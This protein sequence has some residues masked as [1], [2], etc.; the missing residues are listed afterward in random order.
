MQR[1]IASFGLETSDTHK[2]TS[3]VPLHVYILVHKAPG[4]PDSEACANLGSIIAEVPR[5]LHKYICTY[6]SCSAIS[7]TH[8]PCLIHTNYSTGSY[9]AELCDMLHHGLPWPRQSVLEV[10]IMYVLDILY[11]TLW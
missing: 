1:S 6:Q 9:W 8:S 10:V 7:G 4:H 3:C 11:E 2:Y 5:W